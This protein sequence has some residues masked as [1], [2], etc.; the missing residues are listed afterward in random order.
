MLCGAL[1]AL[2][3]GGAWAAPAAL[4]GDIGRPFEGILPVPGALPAAGAP[5]LPPR[6]PFHLAPAI[7]VELAVKAARA[8]DAACPQYPLGVAVTDAEGVPK[9]IYVPDRS[10]SWHGFSAVRKAYTA[11]IFKSD[12]SIVM[13]RAQQ[14]PEVAA[15][16]HADPNLQAFSGALLLKVNDVIS[17]ALAV[18]GAEP[19]GHDEECARAGLKAIQD[20]LKQIP[21]EPAR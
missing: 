19:G 8:V 14:E 9:L 21:R 10:E 1:A 20:D 6:P 18:S 13:K 2:P 17:G 3:M 11:V 12:T 7:P 5:G 4:P 16:V 15:K